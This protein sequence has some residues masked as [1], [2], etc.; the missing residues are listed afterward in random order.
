MPGRS[1]QATRAAPVSQ[2][3]PMS[4][5]D[6][7]KAKLRA[8]H[9]Q[10]KYGKIGSSS[11]GSNEVKTE[12]LNKS[13]TTQASIVLPV[14]KALV[15]P[16]IEEHKKSVMVQSKISCKLED[17]LDSKQKMDTKVPS[18]EKCNRVLIRWQTPPGT[19]AFSVFLLVPCVFANN[20]SVKRISLYFPEP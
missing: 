7:Q 17:P 10:N 15:R 3:R 18:E 20:I 11:N 2:A 9:M 1:P 8:M 12:G 5:D 14:S 6:I 19:L 13:T 4:A 16:Q